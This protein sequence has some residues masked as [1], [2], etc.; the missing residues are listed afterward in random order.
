MLY[1][2]GQVD[3]AR[4][5]LYVLGQQPDSSE[6]QRL[7]AVEKHISKC[8]DARKIGDWKMALKECDAAI[9][10]GADYCPQVIDFSNLSF[11]GF[12]SVGHS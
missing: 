2:L 9:S 10:A 5:H 11:Y 6:I 3:N 8:M 7:L 4:K 12:I 1:R